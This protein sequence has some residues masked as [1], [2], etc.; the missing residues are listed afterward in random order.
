MQLDD[1]NLDL[2]EP[3]LRRMVELIGIEATFAVVHAHG[4]MLLNIA[5]RADQNAHLVDLVGAENARALG[6][7]WGG[8]RPFIPKAQAALKHLRNQQI[9]RD[10]QQ[11]SV[12]EVARR[13][14]LGERRIW[15]LKNELD[16]VDDSG[17]RGLFD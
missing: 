10:L 12:R 9:T 8:Q 2:L 1:L 16:L 13:N 15:Q 5:Q 4:G 3:V 17:N 11:L 6:L 7:E 14:R